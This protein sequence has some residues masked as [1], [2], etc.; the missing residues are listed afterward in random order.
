LPH[1]PCQTVELPNDNGIAVSGLIKGF[2]EFRTIR[3]HTR[4]FL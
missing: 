3:L 1:R 4:G 2:D